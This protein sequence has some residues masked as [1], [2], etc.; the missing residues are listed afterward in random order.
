VDTTAKK[1]HLRNNQGRDPGANEWTSSGV[2]VQRKGERMGFSIKRL[3][4]T[5]L[6]ASGPFAI[7]PFF[8]IAF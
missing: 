6:H 1:T 5:F 2:N 8:D 4:A 3:A 7:T